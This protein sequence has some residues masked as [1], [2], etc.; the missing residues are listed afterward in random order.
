MTILTP[1]KFNF[2]QLMVAL[3]FGIRASEPPAPWAWRTTEKA[4]PD[5]VKNHENLAFLPILD[6]HKTNTE[7]NF[8]NPHGKIW[9]LK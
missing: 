2:N 6:C 9:I 1:A 7:T 5:R 4:G 3:I 8:E